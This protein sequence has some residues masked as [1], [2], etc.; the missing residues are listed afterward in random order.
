LAQEQNP[1][2]QS[3]PQPLYAVTIHHCIA[4]GDLQQMKNLVKEAE[5][6]IKSHGNVAAA[7]ELLKGE[8]AKH[9]HK[10]K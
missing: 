7:L 5:E 10:H 4:G 1:Q 8:I 2:G 3:R 9:E 6:H